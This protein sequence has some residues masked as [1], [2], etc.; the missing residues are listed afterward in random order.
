MGRVSKGERPHGQRPFAPR[1]PPCPRRPLQPFPPRAPVARMDA[2]A[3]PLSLAWVASAFGFALAMS[4]TPG[5]NN[6]MMTASGATWG[7]RRSIPHMLGITFGFPAML[8]ALAFGAGE[9][10]VRYPQAHRIAGWAG[11]AYMLWLAWRI[12]TATPE[13]PA[14]SQSPLPSH[15]RKGEGAAGRRSL[16]AR[17]LAPRGRPLGFLEAALFQW[18]NPKAWVIT[19]G[20]IATYTTAGSGAVVAQTLA[21]AVIFALACFPSV[22]LWTAIGMG[23]ARVLRTPRAIRAFNAAMAALLVASLVPL[24]A[25]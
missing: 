13:P 5:P 21:L 11:A 18:I 8:A 22:G 1:M 23:A 2:A 15:A 19:L 3:E 9:L 6:V 25:G 16:R 7:F 10:L 12:A 14:P 24:V 4:A 17:L 20:A